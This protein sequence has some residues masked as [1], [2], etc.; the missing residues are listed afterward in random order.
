MKQSVHQVLNAFYV[1]GLEELEVL[2]LTGYSILLEERPD[3]DHPVLGTADE[4]LSIRAVKL[5]ELILLQLVK[6][7]LALE[8]VLVA[9]FDILEEDLGG[10]VV[11][12]ANETGD[13][14]SREIFKGRLLLWT[15]ELDADAVVVGSWG[16]AQTELT[17]LEKTVKLGDGNLQAD[18]LSG[19]ELGKRLVVKRF[20][21]EAGNG[22]VLSLLLGN[23][24]LAPRVPFTCG[25]VQLTLALDKDI[26]ELAVRSDPSV[27]DFS[28]QS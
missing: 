8:V 4:I 5:K 12:S 25:I 11:P 7:D 6:V 28:G 1:A 14:A 13:L 20:E 10:D 15:L 23:L 9:F 22:V 26:C 19:E 21:V 18:V 16:L 3:L 2:A 27:L 24:E 17:A